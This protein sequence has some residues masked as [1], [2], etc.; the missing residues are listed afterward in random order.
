MNSLSLTGIYKGNCAQ[1]Q[2]YAWFNKPENFVCSHTLRLN[3]M[4]SYSLFAD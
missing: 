3:S 1:V 4:Q 2:E